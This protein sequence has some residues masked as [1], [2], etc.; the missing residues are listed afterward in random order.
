MCFY[1]NE[2]FMWREK[3]NADK[4][5]VDWLMNVWLSF[6]IEEGSDIFQTDLSF[7]Q[8]T[9]VMKYISFLSIKQTLT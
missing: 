4:S 7:K 9:K 3:C 6:N 1:A 5:N 8:S 2:C